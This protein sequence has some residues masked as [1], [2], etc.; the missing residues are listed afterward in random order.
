MRNHQ[1]TQTPNTEHFNSAEIKDIINKIQHKGIDPRAFIDHA[2]FMEED[3]FFT[4]QRTALFETMFELY[5]KE[6]GE[7][8]SHQSDIAS[9][10]CLMY[11]M[12]D[13]SAQ[14][15]AE[16]QSSLDNIGTWKRV[17]YEL[18]EHFGFND[19]KI[20]ELKSYVTHNGQFSEL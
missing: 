4:L 18:K 1:T 15:M 19:T 9:T 14:A 5:T 8:N 13:E 6:L 16:K 12:F 20:Q 2:E 3:G 10:L 17:R 7:G 11:R